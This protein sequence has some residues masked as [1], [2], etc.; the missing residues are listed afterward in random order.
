MGVTLTSRHVKTTESQ[1]LN[2]GH[3]LYHAP[4]RAVHCIMNLQLVVPGTSLAESCFFFFSV[5]NVRYCYGK[6]ASTRVV[7][8]FSNSE[9]TIAEYDQ[10]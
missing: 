7:F 10:H 2:P 4:M 6:R 1:M 9:D 5:G 8:P 3:I